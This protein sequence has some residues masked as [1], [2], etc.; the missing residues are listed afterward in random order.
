MAADEEEVVEFG[1][2]TKGQLRELIL[3]RLEHAATDSLGWQAS[4]RELVLQ[5]VK[6]TFLMNGGALIALMAFLGTS[7]AAEIF[8]GRYNALEEAM[9]CFVIGLSVSVTSGAIHTGAS[10]QYETS[11]R[12]LYSSLSRIAQTG[13]IVDDGKHQQ[14][15]N[16]GSAIEGVGNMFLILSM[17]MFTQGCWSA[18]DKF[19]AAG[20]SI[21]ARPSA[22]S[23]DATARQRVSPRPPKPAGE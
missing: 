19:V 5:G 18:A 10:I 12:D 3:K 2:P 1:V 22:V 20:S 16:M 9:T 8:A 17:I 23:S 11:S 6:S 7:T 21:S 4:T 15:I 13:Q 14:R